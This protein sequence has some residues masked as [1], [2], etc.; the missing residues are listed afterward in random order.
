M[1]RN[2]II[3]IEVGDDSYPTNCYIIYDENKNGVVIDPGF[4]KNRIIKEIEDNELKIKHVILTHCHADHL[5]ELTSICEYAKCDCI[6]NENDKDGLEDDEKAHF[7]KLNIT[8]PDL[9]KFKVKTVKDKDII[10]IGSIQLEVI[11]TPGHTSGCMCLFEKQTSSLF[12]GDTIFAQCYGRVDLKSGS[13]EDIKESI[14]KLFN[15]FTDVIIYPGHE[16]IV[17]ID[18]AKRRINLLLKIRRS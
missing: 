18:S 6:I 10:E 13:F 16:D 12:T 14:D 15:R 7:T 2:K 8:K 11:N 17:N 4:D 1:E 3:Q 9:S 5:G